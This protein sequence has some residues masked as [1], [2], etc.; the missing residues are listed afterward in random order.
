MVGVEYLDVFEV[1][2]CEIDVGEGVSEIGDDGVFFE[3]GD[4]GEGI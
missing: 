1:V 4:V 3:M 2:L